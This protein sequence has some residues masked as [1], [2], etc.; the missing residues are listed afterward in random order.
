MK[1]PGE[2]HRKALGI[3]PVAAPAWPWVTCRLRL[4]RTTELPSEECISRHEHLPLLAHPNS[5]LYSSSEADILI[6]VHVTV[7][8]SS[9]PTCPLSN[10][11]KGGATVSTSQRSLAWGLACTGQRSGCTG[12]PWQAPSFSLTE[13]VSSLGLG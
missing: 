5:L 11:K 2:G 1:T 3:W 4:R 7:K 12:I 13:S 8:L 10:P 6:L 9:V